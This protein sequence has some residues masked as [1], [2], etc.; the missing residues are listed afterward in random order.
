MIDTGKLYDFT[1]DVISGLGPLSV[2]DMHDEAM[3]VKK[4]DGG[5]VTRADMQYLVDIGIIAGHDDYVINHD[6]VTAGFF[7]AALP[8]ARLHTMS[9]IAGMLEAARKRRGDHGRP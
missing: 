8:A 6:G 9:E 2:T 1:S 3:T 4:K 7:P 5:A